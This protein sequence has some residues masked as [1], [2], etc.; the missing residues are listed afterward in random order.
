M[1][2]CGRGVLSG[3]AAPTGNAG[4]NPAPATSLPGALDLRY[5]EVRVPAPPQ[6]GGVAQ[7]VGHTRKSLGTLVAKL[8]CQVRILRILPSELPDSSAPESCRECGGTPKKT[9]TLT[10]HSFCLVQIGRAHV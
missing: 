10:S 4:S 8:R 5:F 9:G 1:H 3:N 2:R 7:L 6:P